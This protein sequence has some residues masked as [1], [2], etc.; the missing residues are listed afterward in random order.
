MTEYKFFRN[1]PGYGWWLL[2]S[3][4]AGVIANGDHITNFG[5]QSG[6]TQVKLTYNA[7]NVI[8][9]P[10]FPVAVEITTVP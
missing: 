6:D 9:V 1:I 10:L 5:I 3:V 4:G 8:P 2:C 7:T